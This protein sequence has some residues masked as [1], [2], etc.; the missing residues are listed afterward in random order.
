ML[1]FKKIATL[2][3]FAMIVASAIAIVAL[4]FWGIELDINYIYTAL[5]IGLGGAVWLGLLARK[6]YESFD[7]IEATPSPAWFWQLVFNRLP[8][9]KGSLQSMTK[10]RILLVTDTEHLSL[11]EEIE[12]Q[13]ED[14]HLTIDVFECDAPSDEVDGNEAL[15]QQLLDKQ[16]AY[17]FWTP[18]MKGLEWP[19]RTLL[20][21]SVANSHKAVL[22]IDALR[23]DAYELTF[24]SVPLDRAKTDL[25]RLLARS[26][27]RAGLWKAQ[28]EKYRSVSLGLAAFSL[29]AIV[30]SSIGLIV[31]DQQAGEAREAAVSILTARA[32][33]LAAD[34]QAE[35]TADLNGIQGPAVTVELFREVPVRVGGE[36][37]SCYCEVA[38][39]NELS[40][41]CFDSQG[42]GIISC[43]MRDT[44]AVA[45]H[46]AEKAEGMPA[47]WSLAGQERGVWV[48][49]EIKLDT[50]SICRF[51]VK[52]NDRVREALSCV[53]VRDQ[54][55]GEP[56]GVCLD[57]VKYDEN[58]LFTDTTR[59]R[60]S[61]V[62]RLVSQPELGAFA[63]RSLS[64]R[65]KAEFQTQ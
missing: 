34:F 30:G 33:L 56:G 65:C 32:K 13:Y 41:H 2:L 19:H 47:A 54:E 61:R 26:T 59:L 12:Q 5:G 9:T 45:W 7:T 55:T 28:A 24:N 31:F 44:L 10:T 29:L 25:W 49:D 42:D 21:W 64:E 43:A 6:A 52:K 15:G 58:L 23:D 35:S 3:P 50:E 48:N 37:R 16:A 36:S 40:P 8:S 4:E 39:S 11:A 60:L 46:T 63:Q 22:A 18:A 17:F 14:S 53:G 20:K 51:K 1:M 27:D 57:L 38:G 62:A